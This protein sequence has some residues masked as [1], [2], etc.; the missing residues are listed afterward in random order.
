M[1]RAF[2]NC[3]MV[4]KKHLN[5]FYFQWKKMNQ[6]C[7]E[8]LRSYLKWLHNW[9]LKSR[10]RS[11][12]L[13]GSHSMG[14]G[15]ILLKPR[16]DD[17]FKKVLSMSLI[18]AGSISVDSTFNKFLKGPI[19]GYSFVNLCKLFWVNL[20]RIILILGNSIELWYLKLLLWVFLYKSDI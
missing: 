11:H 5:F 12:A 6:V 15:R 8:Y 2:V 4:L 16:R 18:W 19:V 10:R 1:L 7:S 9:Q 13:K 14:D 20:I 17:S 3:A